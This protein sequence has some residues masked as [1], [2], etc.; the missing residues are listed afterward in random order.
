MS[1]R[2][3]RQWNLSCRLGPILYFAAL[4]LLALSLIAVDRM[5]TEPEMRDAPLSAPERLAV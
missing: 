5:R 3:P 1:A 4:L 2:R